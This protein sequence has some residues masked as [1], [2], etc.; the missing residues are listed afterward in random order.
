MK[1]SGL[2]SIINDRIKEIQT[3]YSEMQHVDVSVLDHANHFIAR[4]I[5]DLEMLKT[6]LVSDLDAELQNLGDMR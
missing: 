1:I 4:S 5:E 3:L 2:W 6:L